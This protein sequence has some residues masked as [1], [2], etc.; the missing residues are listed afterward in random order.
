MLYVVVDF[1][2]VYVVASSARL[3][4]LNLLVLG[5]GAVWASVAHPEIFR[6]PAPVLLIGAVVVLALGVAAWYYL[7]ELIFNIQANRDI[8]GR[9]NWSI[10]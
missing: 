7:G 2:A 10:R 4:L 9:R 1:V 8:R 5:G 6:L 3:W